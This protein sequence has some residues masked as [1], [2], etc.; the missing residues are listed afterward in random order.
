MAH[1]TLERLEQFAIDVILERRYGRKAALLRLVLRGLSWVYGGM[2][3]FRWWLYENRILPW[4]SVG[5]LTIS[6]GN[7]TVGGTGKTPIVEML[8]RVLRQSGRRVAILSRGYKSRPR[9]LIQRVFDSLLRGGAPD[10]PRVVSDGRALLLDSQVAGDEPYMLASNLPDVAVLVDKNRVKSALYAVEKMGIDTLL[11]DDGFQYLPLKERINLVLV[12][13][14][15]PFGNGYIL[16]RGTLREPKDHLRRA[17]VIFITKCDGSDLSG[18]KAELRRYNRHAEI[19]ECAHRPRYL[20]DLYTDE[21][22]PLSFLV[23]RNVGAVC[24]IAVPESFRQGLEDLGARIIYFREYADHHRFTEQEVIN[25][26]N[27]TIARKGTAL[28]TTEKDAV[29]FP[30]VHRRDLPVLFLRVEIN[31]LDPELRFAEV[32]RRIC[33]LEKDSSAKGVEVASRG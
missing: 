33:R 19:L 32:V 11:L 12:D 2:M 6:V 21:I 13:R 7:L 23:D 3:R 5:C 22:H 20:V 25:A 24:G 30:K 10:P 14:T 1:R 26:I 17:D 28:I 29:R 8:A 16:P 9:P 31:L 4:A 18:L 15:A 27:R